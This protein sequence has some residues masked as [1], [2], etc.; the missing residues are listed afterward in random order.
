MVTSL[1]DLGMVFILV[2]AFRIGRIALD[3]RV[4]PKCALGCILSE[5]CV[6]SYEEIRRYYVQLEAAGIVPPHLRREIL[7][8]KAFVIGGFVRLMMCNTR[9]FQQAILFDDAKIDPR[10]SS[11]Q[12]DMQETMVKSLVRE[13]AQVR[14]ELYKCQ[15][16]LLVRA[17]FRLNVNQQVVMRLVGLYKKLEED[18][19]AWADMSD[20]KTYHTMLLERLGLLSWG[21]V[22]GNGSGI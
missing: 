6:V 13:T 14:W 9:L 17:A 20:D 19:V 16:S 11:L 12:L 10:K 4:P 18:L 1:L 3:L 15:L 2:L 22:D 7:R 5:L 21:V 8:K